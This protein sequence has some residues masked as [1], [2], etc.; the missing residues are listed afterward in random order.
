MKPDALS[1]TNTGKA[2]LKNFH[3]AD[4]GAARSLLNSLTL[5]NL[6]E[7]SEL[8]QEQLS[9]LALER[10]GKR[11]AVAVYTE[12]E[13]QEKQ[14]FETKQIKKADGSIR[15][16]AIGSKG[17]PAVKPIRGGVRVGSEGTLS[18]LIAQ[19]VKK[20]P[21]VL[22][23]TPGPERFRSEN[24][25]VSTI[26]IVT[27]F[28]GSGTRLLT[29]LNKFWNVKTVKSWHSTKLVDFVVVA[30]AATSKGAAAV[31]S[32]TSRPDVRVGR[33]VPTLDSSRFLQLYWDWSNLLQK[34]SEDDPD[35]DYIWGYKDSAAM[36]LFSYGIPN[37]APSILWKATGAIKPLYVGNIPSELRLLFWSGSKSEQVERAARERG[38]QLDP[39]V[40]IKDQ[41]VLLVLQELR[42]RFT[43]QKH[44]ERK[45]RALSESLSLTEADIREAVN[46][47]YLRKLITSNGRLTEQGYD[48][49]RAQ[50]IARERNIIVPS[51]TDPY[52]PMS[53]RASK[54]ASSTR[55]PKGRP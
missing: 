9:E 2:W 37:N 29:M 32:H 12:R 3:G 27:D 43:G 35:D 15:E 8:I 7:V 50:S 28:I 21:R 40:D 6:D 5:I 1:K 11:K 34:F 10:S 25:P 49:L 16:R 38:H 44:Y 51:N 13:F 54:D 39:S 47:A 20:H 41:I 31:R 23:N 4:R 53:L 18:S 22:I 48:E 30:A 17:P 45:L 33:T 26:A 55:R 14:A 24:S 52:Y 19:T 36:V 46:I 42:G